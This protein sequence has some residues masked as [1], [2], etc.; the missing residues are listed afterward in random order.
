MSNVTFHQVIIAAYIRV[1]TDEQAKHG[2]SI[3][4]QKERIIQY[5]K[6][7]GLGTPVFY[8]DDG[9]SGKNMKRPELTRLLRN[10]EAGEVAMVITTKLDRLSRKL[11]HTLK[12]I[13]QLQRCH[14]KYTCLNMDMDLN[15]PQGMLMLQNMGSFAEFEREMTRER[16]RDNLL[17]I[18]RKASET[19]KAFTIPCYGYDTVDEKFVINEEEAENVRMI[20]NWLLE[21]YGPRLIATRLNSPEY[22]VKTKVGGLWY[23][24]TVRQ[25]VKR[26][27]LFGALVYNRT[28]RRNGEGKTLK[29]PK[30][31]WIVIEDHHPAIIDRETWEEIQITLQ[32][33][34]RS[35][36]Q[37]NNERWLLSGLLYCGHC[38]HKM[39]GYARHKH[40]K[41]T[42]KIQDYFRYKCAGYTEKGICYHHWIDRDDIE[43]LVVDQ[44][45]E[46]A[47]SSQP[48]KLQLVISATKSNEDE[49]RD[50]Q[51]KLERL[52]QKMQR[53]IEAYED[54]LISA[55]DLKRARQRIDDDRVRLHAEIDKL[56][57]G[58][59]EGSVDKV[60]SSVKKR[61]N[62]IGS[63]DRLTQKNAIRQLIHSITIYNGE[64]VEIK[65]NIQ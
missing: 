8:V 18:A 39:V 52:D 10:V 54:E 4:E 40:V 2:N 35:H 5:C 62:Q 22:N 16:V 23:P 34:K 33:R 14:C 7:N 15:T 30:E 50:L 41:A 3:E 53:Q 32:G 9:Y 13:D 27:T 65:Y 17:S 51:I 24:N 6:M 45:K 43:N 26:E 1:S 31:E 57:S 37:A 12:I 38:G 55:D 19:K 48:S 25:L 47:A 20:V 61:E 46:I 49:L 58:E 60:A 29:R 42:N 21:G 64:D 11:Y 28:Y 63:G 36:K 44:L 56:K 59:T